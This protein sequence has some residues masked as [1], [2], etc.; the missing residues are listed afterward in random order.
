MKHSKKVKPKKGIA[1][2]ATG[3]AARKAIKAAE[4]KGIS[5][6]SLGSKTGVNRSASTLSAIKSGSI[7]TPPK[8]LAENINKAVRKTKS[9]GKK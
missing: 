5:L 9:K 1:G 8:S 2:K 7:K 6:T 3:T 4:N